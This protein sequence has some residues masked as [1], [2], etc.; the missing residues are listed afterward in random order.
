M[1]RIKTIIT[2]LLLISVFIT[3]LKTS[4]YFQ[5]KSDLKLFQD[6][7]K[8]SLTGRLYSVS[9]EQK[10]TA[11]RVSG[12]QQKLIFYPRTDGKLNN[13]HFFTTFAEVGDSVKKA[14]Y[15]DTLFLIK[16]K[17]KYIYLFRKHL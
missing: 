8:A 10:G 2:L 3:L 12:I 14:R 1:S 17:V 15:N 6:F 5:S 13:G 11:I 9:T 4:L 16:D 7:N